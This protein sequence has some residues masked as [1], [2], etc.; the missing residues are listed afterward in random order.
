VMIQERRGMMKVWNL[1]L[2]IISFLLTIVG[3]YMTRSGVVQSVHAFGEDPVLAWTF[4]A[5]MLAI[6]VVSF[7][8]L[9]WRM[10]RLRSEN[11]LESVLSREFAFLVNNWLF[12]VCAVFVLGAT[13]YPTIWEWVSELLRDHFPGAYEALHAKAI[14]DP[15]AWGWL[16]PEGRRVIGPPFFNRY[17]RPIGLALLLLTGVGPLVAWRKTSEKQ[18]V[19]QFAGP[20][21]FGAGSTGAAALLAGAESVWGLACFGLCGFTLWTIIQEFYRGVAARRRNRKERVLD[22][23]IRLTLRA[24][25]RYGGYIVHLGVVLMFFGWAGNAYKVERKVTLKPGQETHLGGYQIR[26]DGL[27]ATED[28]QKEMITA[29]IA[30]VRD[31]EVLEVLQPARWWYYQLPEQ[32]TTEVSRYMTPLEDVYVSVQTVDMTTGWTQL[33][34]YINPLVNWIW[35]GFIVMLMGSLICVGTRREEKKPR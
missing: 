25:R 28:W 23:L 32:P 21:A 8:L 4:G 24:R 27:R 14:A 30:V 33:S 29:D 26:H 1:S 3:T 10:P 13:M 19:R 16:D 22:A 11:E 17:M 7:G 5:F 6:V 9:F 15:D 20:L 34:L 12:V 31:G 18:L 2:I 35:V